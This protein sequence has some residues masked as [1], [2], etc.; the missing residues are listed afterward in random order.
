MKHDDAGTNF[1]II[2]G[3]CSIDTLWRRLLLIRGFF[4]NMG[5]RVETFTLLFVS[6]NFD[7][8]TNLEGTE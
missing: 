7:N 6:F 2:V 5:I 8:G 4:G 1:G 3:T